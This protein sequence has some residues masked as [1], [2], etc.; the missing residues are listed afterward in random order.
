MRIIKTGR[1]RA[2]LGLTSH[3]PSQATIK[4]GSAKPER[5]RNRVESAKPVAVARRSKK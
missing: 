3:V 4:R 5:N 2:G 1:P